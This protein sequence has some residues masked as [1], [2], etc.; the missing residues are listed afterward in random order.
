MGRSL[1][2]EGQRCRENVLEGCGGVAGLEGNVAGDEVE[3]CHGC[4][5][6]IDGG[7]EHLAPID[8]FRH[9]D[10]GGEVC[11]ERSVLLHPLRERLAVEELEDEED[12]EDEW[13]AVDDFF[14][15]LVDTNDRRMLEA[16]RDLGL[17]KG[18]LAKALGDDRFDGDGT[19]KPLAERAPDLAGAAAADLVLEAIAR[20][21]AAA[22]T[23][24]Y[25]PSLT[26][27]LHRGG[28]RV[29]LVSCPAPRRLLA[30]ARGHTHVREYLRRVDSKDSHLRTTGPTV[31][32]PRDGPKPLDSENVAAGIRS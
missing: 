27:A 9:H 28:G 15:D 20:S 22:R 3:K 6:L 12:E 4:T 11:I 31:V 7:K 23:Q 25:L 16:R 30:R 29:C 5:P 10:L 13:P 14:D 17:T 19:L 8:L 2:G 32:S 18:V 26:N 21:N 1:P 24:A